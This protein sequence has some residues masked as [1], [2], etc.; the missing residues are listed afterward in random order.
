MNMT[1][2]TKDHELFHLYSKAAGFAKLDA[3]KSAAW[4]LEKIDLFTFR[5]LKK[6]NSI[7]INTCNLQRAVWDILS[8]NPTFQHIFFISC[9]SH[10]LQL[11]IKDLFELSSIVELFRKVFK[12]INT[13]QKAKH[14]LAILWSYQITLYSQ[15][16]ILIASTIFR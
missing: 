3:Q 2:F 14:H 5:N 12:I 10:G 1:V 15:K 13:L 4:I 11:L 16:K 7:A 6:I 9:D 8:H